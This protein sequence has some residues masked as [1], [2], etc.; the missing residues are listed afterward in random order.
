MDLFLSATS[1]SGPVISWLSRK[2][3]L[4]TLGTLIFSDVVEKK[5]RNM[6]SC[7]T[8]VHVLSDFAGGSY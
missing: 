7:L 5:N 8:A 6:L 1:S 4:P 2:K 3:D